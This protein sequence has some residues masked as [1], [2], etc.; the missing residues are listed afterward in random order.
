MSPLHNLQTEIVLQK[1]NRFFVQVFH[2]FPDIIIVG[3]EVLEPEEF[4]ALLHEK[5]ISEVK[6]DSFGKTYGLSRKGEL[7]MTEKTLLLT[8]APHESML[9]AS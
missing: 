4:K 9:I 7:Y 2:Y 5:Y 3:N 1:I 8:N 6:N